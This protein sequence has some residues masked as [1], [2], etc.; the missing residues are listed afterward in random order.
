MFTCICL[1]AGL[2]TR[3][4]SPKAL[5]QIN[6]E[7]AITFIQKKFL[8]TSCDE[9]IIVLGAHA[10]QIKAHVLNHK[11]IRIVYNKDYSLGQTSSVQAGLCDVSSETSAALL[12]PVDC[13]FIDASTVDLMLKS[14]IAQPA[15]ISIPTIDDKRGHPPVLAFPLFQHIRSLSKNLG[16]NTLFD[17][18]QDEIHY[19][20]VND[21][22]IRLTFNT[23]QELTSILDRQ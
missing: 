7:P 19:V 13:P 2:S 9:L 17:L 23:P 6:H 21:P 5:A 10:D 1:A 4:G 16:I 11:R 22:G 20:P 14:F 12:W 18:H 8:S 3:F 15:L